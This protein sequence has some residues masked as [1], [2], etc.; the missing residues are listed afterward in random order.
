MP[1]REPSEA[2][3]NAVRKH[4]REKVDK[5]TVRL[6]KGTKDQILST[7]QAVNS[8]VIQAVMEKLSLDVQTDSNN[9]AC[10][11]AE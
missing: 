4:D 10:N 6:P 9:A 1:V 8:F 3:R 11:D 2:Q 7:G 5:V